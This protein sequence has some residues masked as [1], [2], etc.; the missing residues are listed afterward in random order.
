MKIKLKDMSIEDMKVFD[1]KVCGKLIKCIECPF[2]R[3][4]C[5]NDNCWVRHKDLYSDDFLNQEIE[6]PQDNLLTEKDRAFILDKIRELEYDIIGVIKTRFDIIEIHI[7]FGAF[8]QTFVIQY[9]P[10][11]NNYMF[12]NLEKGKLYT[13]E[14]LGIDEEN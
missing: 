7:K 8:N 3:V 10:F 4:S 12:R 2:S 13:L 6:I 14:E 9:P 5:D 11:K 1:E